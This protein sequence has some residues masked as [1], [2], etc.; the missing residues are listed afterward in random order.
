ME[1]T[2]LTRSVLPA[3]SWSSFF[4]AVNDAMALHLSSA[5]PPGQK[6]PVL[7][8]EYPK[9]T[10]GKFDDSFDVILY[11]V[12]KSERAGTD[13]TGLQRKPTGPT[14]RE[15]IVHPS[16]GRYHLQTAAWWENMTFEFKVLAK[17]N[18]RADELVEW[19][20]RFMIEY[21]WSLGFFKARGVNYL[22]Y[23]GRGEDKINKEFGQELYE[24]TIQYMA[25]LELLNSFET[26]DLESL[27]VTIEGKPQ[28]EIDIVEEYIIPS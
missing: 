4:E 11:H 8:R 18:D 27:N 24:R 22:V 25:R 10:L 26:K 19:F 28:Q 13:R 1:I 21:T 2:N 5:N 16:K 14:P 7:V 6:A 23:N 17:S 20:H 15:Q 12:V 3:V 9:T